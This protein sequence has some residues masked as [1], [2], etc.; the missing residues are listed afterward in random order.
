ML[1][2]FWDGLDHHVQRNGGDLEEG[3]W[4][5]M[6][7]ELEKTW[8]WV[9]WDIYRMGVPPPSHWLWVHTLHAWDV[10]GLTPFSIKSN[11]LFRAST[12]TCLC[13]GSCLGV[14]LLK[15][16]VLLL[17]R[18]Y[19]VYFYRCFWANALARVFLLFV[20]AL[21]RFCCECARR[22]IWVCRNDNG[23]RSGVSAIEVGIGYF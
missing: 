1:G 13:A 22:A 8:S 6:W 9:V 16:F 20:R 15:A 5:D 18:K 10:P 17:V 11:F 21:Y 7:M 14:L 3:S 12:Q 19:C 23:P 4:P 2:V